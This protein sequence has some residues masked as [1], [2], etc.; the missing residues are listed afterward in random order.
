[1][2]KKISSNNSLIIFLIVTGVLLR[3]QLLTVNPPNNT[4][5]DHLEVIKYYAETNQ[6]P[7]PFKCWECY[8]PPAYYF[9]SSYIYNLSNNLNL[10][11]ISRWKIVQ[12]I[13]ILFSI[14]IILLA[15]KILLLVNI[16]RF[17]VALCMSFIISFPRDLFT[18][19]IIGND[20]MLVF[21]S[22]LCFYLFLKS[23]IN[24]QKKRFFLPYFIGLVLIA[25]LGDLT[26]QQGL[27]LF[28]FPFLLF[29]S[30]TR[31]STPKLFIIQII[32]LFLGAA[33]CIY[34][35]Y[36]KYNQTGIMLVS[37]QHFFNYASNQF[38][39]SLAKVEFL[40]FR[41][42][43]LM[44]F[45]F[46]SNDTSASFFTEIFARSFFDYEWRFISPDVKESF[47]AGRFSYLTGLTWIMLGLYAT[48]RYIK[49]LKN[50][51]NTSSD[52]N[53]LIPI[54]VSLLF[55]CVPLMQTIRFPY[56]S[57]MKSMFMLSGLLIYIICMGSQ[58]ETSSKMKKLGYIMIFIN[59][60][61]AIT[62]VYSI[63]ENI[64]KSIANL[65]GPLWPI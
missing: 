28:C 17:I 3:I 36:W 33:A 21:C 1:M 43:N 13:N 39:G 44:S 9:L 37:N 48:I 60:L 61:N 49:K 54:L 20:Y 41:I 42:I 40:T 47:I 62:L 45:P 16:N 14:A 18:S 5:D 46:L 51:L 64:H 57:S 34:E 2:F 56:F 7:A 4:F 58:L 31:K 26:K 25:T 53:L 10:D 30:T 15:L 29:L 50:S 8:Q 55:F 65:S 59:V 38:P 12:T 35:E 19:S 24:F 23:L 6:R 22:I 32:I 63:S 27:I 52:Y 11:E